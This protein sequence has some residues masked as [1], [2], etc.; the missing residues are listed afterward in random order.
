MQSL[1]DKTA[2]VTGAGKGIG[3][4]IALALAAEGVHVGL[5]ARTGKDIAA[6][7]E[8]IKAMGVKA[9]YAAADVSNRQEVEA[10][11]EKI[12]GELGPIDILVN[13]AG[14]ATFGKFLELEP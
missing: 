14:T 11:V 7:A 4:A 9:S 8:E 6:A 5:V 10:A 2:L 1:K 12:K 13:N 3:K